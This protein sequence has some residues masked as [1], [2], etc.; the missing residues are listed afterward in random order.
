VAI[1]PVGVTQFR[2]KKLKCVDKKVAKETVK[3]ASKYKKVRCSDEIFLLAEE[4]IPPAKYYGSFSQLS[5]GVGA[6][7]LTYDDFK[8][9]KLP[10]SISKPYKIVFAC[11]YAAKNM[12]EKIAIKLNKIKNLTVKIC[13]VKSSYWGEDITVAGLITTD[14]LIKTVKNEVCNL[15]IIPSVMFR[16]YTQDFLDGQNLDYVKKQS[17]KNFFVQQNIYSLK[18]VIDFIKKI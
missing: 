16:P 9:Q 13:P 4:P 6:L 1:V 7:R 15:V 8:K 5:D 2:E 18:E 3:I 11:S 12:L 14:D 17:D 10:R